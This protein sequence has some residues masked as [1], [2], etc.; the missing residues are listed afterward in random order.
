MQSQPIK[1]NFKEEI[2]KYLLNWKWILLSVILSFLACYLYLRYASDIYETSAKIQVLDSSSSSFKMPN[3][4]VSIFSNSKINLEN[5]IENIKSSRIIGSV[6]DSLNL[7]TEIYSVGRLKSYELWNNSPI[8]VIWALEKDSLN[9]KT[10]IFEIEI[11]KTGYKLIGSEKEF[12]FGQTNF[13][14]KI[15]FKIN[16]N[17]NVSLNKIEGRVYQISLKNKKNVWQS[18]SRKISIDYVGNQSDI[19]KIHLTGYNKEKITD[20]INTLIFIFNNDGVKDRQFV[21]QKTVDFVDKRFEYLYNELDSIEQSKADYKRSNEVVNVDNDASFLMQKTFVSKSDLDNANTQLTLSKLMLLSINKSKGMELLP[22]NIGIE[23]QEINTLINSYN[24]EVFKYNKLVQSG[25]GESNPLVKQTQNLAYQ[26]KNNVRSSIIGYRKV[27]EINKNE[28]SKINTEE[29]IKFGSVPNKEKNIRSI[30]RQQTIKE[31]LY[32]LLL[33]K[34]EEALVNLAITNPCIKVVEYS[35][36]SDSPI[37]P[38][39]KSYFGIALLIGFIIPFIFIYFNNLYNNKIQ[40]KEDIEE[41]IKDMMV[42]SEIPNIK[43]EQKKVVLLDRSILSE[44][45]RILSSNI[46]YITTPKKEG[47]VIFVTSSVKGEG[48]T[49]VSTNLAITLSSFGK[50]VVLV[51][52]DLRNPQLH[53][54]LDLKRVLVKGVANYLFDSKL[55]VNDIITENVESDNLDI[56]ISGIIPQNPAELLSN[57][58]F[59]LL[60]TELKKTYEYVIVDTAPTVLVTDTSLILGLADTILYV[61]RANFTE[62]RLLKFISNFK[63]LNDI[64]SMGIILN[65]IEQNKRYGYKY[66]YGYNYGYGEQEYKNQKKNIWARIGIGFLK[67]R[68]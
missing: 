37:F 49:F 65:N 23:D 26:I 39:R 46:K 55:S 2:F 10:S 43:D 5:Q 60:L 29:K 21:H 34:R 57:G 30:E 62:K 12:K 40:T 63:K 41:E 38:D 8:K 64:K 19:L 15:P 11:T 59:E 24:Q 61:A 42:V 66:N 48:K 52:A 14:F 28:I 13:D 45:F 6:V 68:K 54:A 32:V 56:I 35:T 7:T 16:L 58:R 27:L 1:F 33:Q 22:P 36:F 18:I 31:N 3:E 47:N 9:N 17:S 4:G 44:S 51:G 25:G 20:I 50:K 53:K 67:F